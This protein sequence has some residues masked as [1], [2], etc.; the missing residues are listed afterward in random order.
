MSE[1][2]NFISNLLAKTDIVSLVSR[3]VGLQKKGG[4][5]WGCCPFHHEKTPSFT[6]SDSKQLFY[7]FGCQT[8]GNAITFLSKIE[9]CDN[10]EAIKMF[11]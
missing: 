1:F 7:C 10:F 9:S 3:Y 11:I 2:S 8:G 5:H 4:T 6:V